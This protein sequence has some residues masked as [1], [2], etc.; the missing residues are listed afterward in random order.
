MLREQRFEN[1]GCL[2]LVR[3]GLVGGKRILRHGKRV[4]DRRLHVVAVLARDAFHG[5]SGAH[6]GVGV[7]PGLVIEPTTAAMKPARVVWRAS[8]LRFSA[9]A[10][11]SCSGLPP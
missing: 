6:A 5:T 11:P 8:G 9:A 4:E 10:R 2:Q 3:V 7:S 1:R